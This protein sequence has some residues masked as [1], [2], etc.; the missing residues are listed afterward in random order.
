M[1]LLQLDILIF[2]QRSPP[3]ETRMS[4]QLRE[5]FV[6]LP[7]RWTPRERL[8]VYHPRKPRKLVGHPSKGN[9]SPQYGGRPAFPAESLASWSRQ[10]WFRRPVSRQPLAHARAYRLFRRLRRPLD[11]GK[12]LLTSLPISFSL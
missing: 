2:L 9:E 8:S 7:T 11:E 10:S 3:P 1:V 5:T 6:R 12:V 4:L